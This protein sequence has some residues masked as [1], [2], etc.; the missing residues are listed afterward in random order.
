MS[1]WQDFIGGLASGYFDT[2]VKVSEAEAR[3]AAS[4]TRDDEYSALLNSLLV[5]RETQQMSTPD[6]VAGQ[7]NYQPDY[8]QIAIY[9]GLAVAGLVG[10]G[11]LLKGWK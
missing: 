8:K 3:I 1:E 4:Q 5:Q 11:L 6:T 7:A 9:G 10:A 2:E